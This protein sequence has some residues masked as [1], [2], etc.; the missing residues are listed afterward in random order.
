MIT[1]LLI[2]FAIGFATLNFAAAQ[3]KPGEYAA[4]IKADCGKELKSLCKGVKEGGGRVLACLYSREDK[5]GAKCA[6]TVAASQERLADAVAA[7]ANVRRVCE[8]DAKRLCSGVMPGDGNLID[9]LSQARKA[10]SQTCN[11]TLDAAFLRP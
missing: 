5:L 8:A 4:A 10:V 2:G 11:G 1:R 3:D 7:L 9:C 6:A